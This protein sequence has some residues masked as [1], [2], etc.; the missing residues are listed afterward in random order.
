[1]KEM[2]K[3]VKA[4]ASSLSDL[5]REGRLPAH[6]RNLL[7]NPSFQEAGGGAENYPAA[8]WKGYGSGYTHATN[9]GRPDDGTPGANHAMQMVTTD[10][11]ESSGAM[12]VRVPTSVGCRVLSRV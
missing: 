8:G 5:C 2:K 3:M 10:W 9:M 4:L 12:Q 1:M 6:S 7:L 11:R